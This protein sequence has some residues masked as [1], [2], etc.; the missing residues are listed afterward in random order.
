MSELTWDGEPKLDRPILVVALAGLFDAS[1]VATGAVSWL[2]RHL[3]AEPLAHVAAEP[4]F[5][6]HQARPRVELTPEGNRRVVWPELA[7]HA[8]ARGDGQRD[9]VLLAGL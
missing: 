4:F 6:S 8:T 9:L 7:A 3:R 1:S 5:D 2:V